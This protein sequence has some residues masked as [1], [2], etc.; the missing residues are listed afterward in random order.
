MANMSY[1]KFENAYRDLFDCYGDINS[2]DLSK[3][4]MYYREELVKLCEKIVA[5][6]D[7]TASENPSDSDQE[8]RKELRGSL[9]EAIRKQLRG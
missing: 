4:E 6:Y 8:S 2:D 9:R 7:P 1:V 5:E 3:D